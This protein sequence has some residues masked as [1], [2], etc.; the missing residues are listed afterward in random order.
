MG[1]A[2]GKNLADENKPKIEKALKTEAE[3]GTIEKNPT[4]TKYSITESEVNN[5]FNVPRAVMEKFAA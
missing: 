5:L 2:D 4:N 1:G 3:S